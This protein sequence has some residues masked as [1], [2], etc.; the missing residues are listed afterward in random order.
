MAP[1]GTVRPVARA[2]LG[3][4]GER[5]ACGRT[6]RGRARGGPAR[7]ASLRTD[8]RESEFAVDPVPRVMAAEEWAALGARAGAAPAGARRVRRRRLRPA[9]DD[10]RRGG[11]GGVLG[12]AEHYEPALAGLRPPGRRWIGLAGFDVVRGADGELVVLE[13]NLRTPSGL[14]YAIASRAAVAAT[15]PAGAEPHGV[16]GAIELLGARPAG[17]RAARGARSGGPADRPAH[18]RPRQQRA[19][20]AHVAGARARCP[21]GDPGRPDGARRPA[22]AARHGAAGRRG[23]PADR[24]GPRELG[25]GPPA[26]ARDAPRDARRDQRVRHRRGRRQARAGVRRGHDPVLSGGATM[27]AFRADLRPRPPTRPQGGPRPLRGARR[28]A[29]LRQRRARRGDLPA[30]EARGRRAGPPRRD[31]RS[32][33]VGRAAARAPVDPPDGDRGPARA[34]PR[35]PAAVRRAD[36]GRAGRAARGAHPR[37]VRRRRA[38]RQQLRQRRRQGHVGGGA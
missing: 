14:A 1:G 37:R 21:L 19:L 12:G 26:A 31:R 15:L 24:R 20:G 10:R 9:G 7:A 28:Q 23:L 34:A 18:R 25:P 38:R 35:R 11:A 27:L 33:R 16:D 4:L 13:D 17:R 22:A 32:R 5:R 30:R 29:A 8:G 6:A 3:A 2:A 36:R